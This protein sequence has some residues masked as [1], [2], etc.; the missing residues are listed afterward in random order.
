MFRKHRSGGEE[1]EEGGRIK[2]LLLVLGHVDRDTYQALFIRR[3]DIQWGLPLGKEFL[4][5]LG[6]CPRGI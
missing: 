4:F 2:V 6:D 3:W 5:E 1:G